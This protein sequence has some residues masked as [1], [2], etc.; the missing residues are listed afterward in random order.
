MLNEVGQY[1]KNYALVRMDHKLCAAS[2]EPAD[3]VQGP[4]GLESLI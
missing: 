1:E 3:P 4:W 2:Q